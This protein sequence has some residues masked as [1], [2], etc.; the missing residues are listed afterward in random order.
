LEAQ[1][2]DT[3]AFR[4]TSRRDTRAALPWFGR[5]PSDMPQSPL[6]RRY[7]KRFTL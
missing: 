2:T 5:N 7:E 6:A 3:P 1:A 4:A